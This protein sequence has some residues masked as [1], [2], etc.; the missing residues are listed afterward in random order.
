MGQGFTGLCPEER[1]NIPLVVSETQVR[2][3][4]R[5]ACSWEDTQEHS[6]GDNRARPTPSRAAH[7]HMCYGGG[8]L[9][10][11][12]Y[13]PAGIIIIWQE[14][15]AYCHKQ[16]LV[17]TGVIVRESGWG[18]SPWLQGGGDHVG[19][20]NDLGLSLSP[21]GSHPATV[22]P[23]GQAPSCHWVRRQKHLE[24][25]CCESERF[26]ASGLKPW[27]GQ[28]D[29]RSLSPLSQVPTACSWSGPIPL[30]T[31]LSSLILRDSHVPRPPPAQ[32]PCSRREGLSFFRA[33][34]QGHEAD[35]RG[36]PWITCVGIC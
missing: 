10:I 33:E 13:S 32:K 27:S 31:S 17:D 15:V 3:T 35:H 23:W 6:V 2:S 36:S 14:D 28:S 26:Q 8:G 1:E 25:E 30:W 21:G 7:A 20:E 19:Q 9:C 16:S 29:P 5:A 4:S 12:I 22:L 11:C 24:G 34:G 18:G